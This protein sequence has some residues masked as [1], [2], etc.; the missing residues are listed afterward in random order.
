MIQEIQKEGNRLFW[1]GTLRI[2]KL[3]LLSGGLRKYPQFLNINCTRGVGIRVNQTKKAPDTSK[4]NEEC[5]K[6]YGKE[7]HGI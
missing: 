3:Q 2:K 1:G 6:R 5:E 4:R 7:F